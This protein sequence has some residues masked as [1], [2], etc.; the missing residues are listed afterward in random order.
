MKKKKRIK[1][2]THILQPRHTNTMGISYII[3]IYYIKS[4]PKTGS[5]Y[6]KIHIIFLL[7][8]ILYQL[9]FANVIFFF[10]MYLIRVENFLIHKYM[11]RF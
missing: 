9:S 1:Y 3:S 5:L 2:D 4:L 6:A 10:F 7:K 8:N 11:I